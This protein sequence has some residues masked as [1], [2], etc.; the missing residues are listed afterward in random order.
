MWHRDRNARSAELIGDCE[1]FLVGHV[2]E[3]IEGRAASVPAWAWMNLLAHGSEHDLCSERAIVRPRQLTS[4]DEWRAARSY[5][6]VEVLNLAAEFGPLAE[7]QRRVLVPLEQR[8]ASRPEVA[9]WR[10]RQWVESVEAALDKHRQACRRT[11]T[12]KTRPPR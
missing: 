12:R 7:L 10:P 11:M 1:A 4:D 9:G 5:L 2:A 6:A 8:L 3:R